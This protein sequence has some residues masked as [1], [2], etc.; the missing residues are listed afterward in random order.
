MADWLP[1]E[2]PGGRPPPRF[3]PSPARRPEAPPAVAPPLA[4]PEPSDRPA[5]VKAGGETNGL[6]VTSL[7]LG[8]VGVTLLVVFVGLSFPI[9]LPC[10]IAAWVCA[11]QARNR[12]SAG[13]ATAGRGQAQAGYI[14]GVIGVLLGVLAAVVWI[15]LIA[16]GVDL[17]ELRRELERQSNPDARRALGHAIAALLPR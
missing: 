9:A 12:I 7:V 3:E 1:P 16:S 4:A 11:A 6:A 2:A 14:L 13:E 17:E 10:S 8:I 5:F 15:G